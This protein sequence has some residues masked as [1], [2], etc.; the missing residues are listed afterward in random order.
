MESVA[1]KTSSLELDVSAWA[2]IA[3]EICNIVTSDVN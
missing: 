2:G 1:M 3:E